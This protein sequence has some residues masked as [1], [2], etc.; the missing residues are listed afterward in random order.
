MQKYSFYMLDC[1]LKSSSLARKISGFLNNIRY[2][3]QAN[4][5]IVIQ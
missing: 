3:F 5:D 4:I 1:V 2:H